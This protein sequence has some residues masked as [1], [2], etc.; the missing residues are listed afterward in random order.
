LALLAHYEGDAQRDRVKDAAYAAIAAARCFGERKRFSFDTYVT[1]HQEAFEDLAQYGHDIP[2][3]KHVRDLL[4][5]I[6]DPKAEAAKQAVLAN[7]NLRTD[8]DAAL[9]HLATSL[10]LNTNLTERNV[11]AVNSGR[12][13]RSGGRSNQGGRGRGRGSRGGR[14]GGGGGRGRGRNIYLGY[15]SPDQI[16]QLSAEDRKRVI[17]GRKRSAEQ[18]SQSQNTNPRNINAIT[19]DSNQIGQEDASA[20]TLD[21]EVRTRQ[22]QTVD[23]SNAGQSM[24]RQRLNAIKSSQR[25]PAKSDM[26]R[27]VS[28]ISS[29]TEIYH[30][31]C[32]L[33]SHAN[34]CVAGPN[35]IILEY[36]DETCN[37]S[38][39][40]KSYE[41][42][43]K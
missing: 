21:T 25:T 23:T 14:Q 10:Q 11:S 9:T 26:P 29:S 2:S 20:V 15:Y 33:D 30:G 19:T 17:E 7:A 5:G 8:F 27:I 24:S 6:K 42:R 3:D 37:V 34:T 36:T 35:C 1:I 12:G 31:F 13:G 39:F 32:E 16:S 18:Q 38:P 40:A 28:R 22:Q 43:T 41:N 4:N